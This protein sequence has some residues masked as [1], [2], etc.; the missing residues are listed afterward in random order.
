MNGKEKSKE[1]MEVIEDVETP[2]EEGNSSEKATAK[3]VENKVP[4]WDT[5]HVIGAN[6]EFQSSS[7]ILKENAKRPGFVRRLWL[8]YK[9]HCILYTILAVLALAAGLPIL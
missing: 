1:E 9:R 4:Y 7:S 8:H 6:R 5:P 3:H 2:E